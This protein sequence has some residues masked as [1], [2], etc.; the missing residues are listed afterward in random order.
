MYKIDKYEICRTVACL[1]IS[2]ATIVG[3]PFIFVYI[4][5]SILKYGL[6]IVVAF[7]GCFLMNLSFKICDKKI[8][9]YKEEHGKEL[10]QES[11]Q[12]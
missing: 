12:L 11:S 7:V 8:K 6:V 5:S 2:M 3:G 9:K 4:S 10:S 1:I